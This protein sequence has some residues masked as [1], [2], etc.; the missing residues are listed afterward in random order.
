MK[1]YSVIALMVLF[2]VSFWNC[3]KDDLC[4]ESTP[5]TPRVV[6]EFYDNNTPTVLKSVTNLGII[7][8]GFTEG[9]SFNNVSKIVAPLK[10]SEDVTILNFIQNGSDEDDMNDNSDQI[11]FNYTRKDIYISRACG[12]KTTFILNDV[13]GVELQTDSDN[14]IQS[15]TVENTSID[16][17]NETHVK[18]YF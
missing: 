5:T 4:A 6:I 12:Y 10:T 11:T 7:S 9:L 13:N 17:E 18:I 15:I 16:N 2:S 1:K 8:P 14:W 3:E